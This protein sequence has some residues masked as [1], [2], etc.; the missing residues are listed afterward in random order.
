MITA[1]SEPAPL[2]QVT[3]WCAGCGTSITRSLP[4]EPLYDTQ[5]VSA[6]IPCTVAAL[7]SHLRRHRPWFPPRYRYQGSGHRLVR[8]LTASEVQRV[9]AAMI[10]S[11]A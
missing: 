9:R 3:L 2:H 4:C 6:I 1:S 11:S 5:V 8:V 7:R 10:R